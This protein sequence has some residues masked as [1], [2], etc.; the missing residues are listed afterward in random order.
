MITGN[1]LESAFNE[2]FTSLIGKEKTLSIIQDCFI[3]IMKLFII[4][5][6]N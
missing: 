3:D 1:T 2:F 5:S 6:I 4:D